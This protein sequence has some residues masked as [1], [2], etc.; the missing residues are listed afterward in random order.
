MALHP[1]EQARQFYGPGPL[2]GTPQPGSPEYEDL[3]DKLMDSYITTPEGRKKLLDALVRPLKT[4]TLASS[5]RGRRRVSKILDEAAK[6]GHDVQ[7]L[8]HLFDQEVQGDE[9][10]H[11]ALDKAVEGLK[12]ED[13]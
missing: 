13:P 2:N 3:A 11:E 5:P 4:G 12:G 1:E 6:D 9:R 7:G 10:L 8:R